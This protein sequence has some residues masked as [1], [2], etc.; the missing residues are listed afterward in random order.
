[1]R[2]YTSPKE[3]KHKIRVGNFTVW[4]I[5]LVSL[6]VSLFYWYQISGLTLENEKLG[7]FEELMLWS[8]VAIGFLSELV[9]KVTLSTFRNKKLWI[10]ATLVSILTVMGSFALLDQSRT[11]ALTKGSDSY[12]TAK[13]DKKEAKLALKDYAHMKGI[14]LKQLDKKEADNFMRGGSNKER[15]ASKMTYRQFLEK[16]K[17]IAKEKVAL[18]EY[19]K[20]KNMVELAEDEMTGSSGGTGAEVSNPL[21]SQIKTVTEFSVSAITLTFFLAVTLLLEISAYYIG[22][23]IQEFKNFLN[24]TEAELLD[25]QNISMFGVSMQAIQRENFARVADALRDRQLADQ[26]IIDLRANR[27]NDNGKKM[28]AGETSQ[29][30]REERTTQEDNHQQA[31]AAQYVIAGSLDVE[32]Q[33]LEALNQRRSDADDNKQS[34][35]PVCPACSTAFPRINR[36]DIFCHPD[37]RRE[38]N[39]Q[40]RRLTRGTPNG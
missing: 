17:E 22:G 27:V 40:I 13:D 14:T 24:L 21:F 4:L 7:L 29:A 3:M 35:T 12:K 18:R 33:T 34:N 26:R 38:F 6:M 10:Y 11:T 19:L 1:M 39:N 37:H 15:V 32:G 28:T 8:A 23:E 5:L 36:Q 25:I 2:L 30:V 9:K 16:G 20:L 31:K